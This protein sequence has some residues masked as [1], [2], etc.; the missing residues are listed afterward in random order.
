MCKALLGKC[1]SRHLFP[2]G[3]LKIVSHGKTKERDAEK[4][5]ITLHD[6]HCL[7]ASKLDFF[8]NAQHSDIMTFLAHFL[9]LQEKDQ[10]LSDNLPVN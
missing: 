8:L 2:Y 6:T 10:K 9:T 7:A 4:K 3:G 5:E 1:T